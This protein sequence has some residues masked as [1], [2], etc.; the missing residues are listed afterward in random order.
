VPG[1][2]GYLPDLTEGAM[3]KTQAGESLVISVVDGEYF[4]NDAKITT[5]NLILENGVAH[6]IDKVSEP[7]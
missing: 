3:L 4:V 5:A 6:V 7:L 1:F 2:V